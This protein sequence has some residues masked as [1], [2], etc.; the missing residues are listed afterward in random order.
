VKTYTLPSLFCPGPWFYPVPWPGVRFA[1]SPAGDTAIALAVYANTPCNMWHETTATV[2]ASF[3]PSGNKLGAVVLNNYDGAIH[4]NDYLNSF[5]IDAT[6]KLTYSHAH[7]PLTPEPWSS[8]WY[9]ISNNASYYD[10]VVPVGADPVTGPWLDPGSL[11]VAPGQVAQAMNSVGLP[12]FNDGLSLVPGNIAIPAMP[13]LGLELDGNGNTYLA[14]T[15]SNSVDF[16]CGALTQ[17]GGNDSFLAK[18]DA[19]NVCVHS[20]RFDVPIEIGVDA[21]GDTIIAAMFSGTVDLGGGPLVSMGPQALGIT[22]LDPQGN[23]LWSESFGGP[24]GV[25]TL[26]ELSVNGPG[27]T[28]LTGTFSGTVDFGSGPVTAQPGSNETFVM[29]I[30]P[31]GSV[32]WTKF[33]SNPGPVGVALDSSGAVML[34]SASPTLDVGSGP[35]LTSPGVA[36]VQLVP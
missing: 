9:L 17:V 28:V 36:L 22:R 19:G 24:G 5:D 15:L 1:S 7:F 16:G 31:F 13:D 29:K 35:V 30:G 21:T 6:G 26:K 23:P 32:D 2:I 33:L 12:M 18:R 25:V 4:Y 20:R 11:A 3:N 10:V 27:E 34:I 8:E 14:G